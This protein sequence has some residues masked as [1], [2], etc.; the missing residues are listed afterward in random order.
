MTGTA[1]D[2]ASA[3]HPAEPGSPGWDG[4]D[5][6]LWLHDALDAVASLG[7]AFHSEDG[8]ALTPEDVFSATR[9]VLRRLAD[10][11]VM[12]LLSVDDEGLG[13]DLAVADPPEA[14]EAILREVEHQTREKTFGWALYQDRPVLVPGSS[15]GRW[16]LLHVLS[17][18]SR[19]SGMFIGSLDSRTPFIPEMAQK[20]LSILLQHCA[21]SLESGHLYR[22]LEEYNRNLE[23]TIDQRTRELRRS[24]EAARAASKAKSQFLANMSHEIRTPLNGILGSTDLLLD[25][26]LSSEQREHALTALRS[27]R[28]LLGLI[29]DVL[30]FS[31]IEAGRVSVER[32]PF[33]LREVVEEVAVAMAPVAH[34]KG[35]EEVVR[36]TPGTPRYLLGDPGKI[37]QILTNLVSNAVKFTESG[38]VTVQA[39]VKAEDREVPR[40]RLS[41][42]DTGVGIEEGD[43]ARIFEEFE[44]AD[45]STTRRFGGTGLGLAISRE[46]TGL[47][48]GTMEV[49]SE[50]GVGSVFSVTLPIPLD[51]EAEIGRRGSFS[52]RGLRALVLSP[53]IPLRDALREELEWIGVEVAMARDSR[54]AR[55][56][57]KKGAAQ[58]A[59]FRLA[60]L[61]AGF[62]GGELASLARWIREEEGQRD[63]VLLALMPRQ[64]R[65]AVGVAD[66]SRMDRVITK[67]VLGGHLAEALDLASGRTGVGKGRDPREAGS[68]GG[69]PELAG[70]ALLV[71]DE[72]VNR[73][74]AQRMLE[75]L[76]LQTRVAREGSEA[77]ELL[78]EEAFDLVL[79]DCYMPGL[80][81]FQATTAIRS[82]EDEHHRIPILALT[83]STLKED[84]EQ[85]LAVGMDGVLVKPLDVE[86][87]GKALVRWLPP[88]DGDEAGQ[89]GD[90]G[91]L[92]RNVDPSVFDAEAALRRVDGEEELLVEVGRIFF[93]GWESQRAILRKA[94]KEGERNTLRQIAHRVRGSSLNLCAG[95]VAERSGELEAAAPG[96]VFEEVQALLVELEEAVDAFRNEFSRALQQE[97]VAA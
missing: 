61:D 13:F 57:L 50:V 28:N 5:D 56:L 82:R 67:P 15:L 22:E 78:E 36:F 14:R 54:D 63:M 83:A 47:L 20:V 48:G 85:C 46:L 25:T 38:H 75:R 52:R 17:T 9:S 16:V 4:E 89:W 21:G 31:K 69:L 51:E 97:G 1:P 90:G 65:R 80:D 95:T 29:N 49:T 26:A 93:Q 91:A 7:R 8:Q 59:P 34:E 86:T 37:R 64:D 79:M 39:E 68:H 96:A 72:E 41:V 81:G 30:D 62:D 84:E 43:L 18:P 70:R 60:L 71:D 35:L 77:L 12:G 66:C 73:L 23:E 40:I 3:A 74:L 2:I 76:G 58:G 92:S 42:K 11:R 87:L 88:T 19:I 44:Q 94:L 53:S 10:F 55:I 32:I 45:A 27:G 24:E 33:D 6:Y